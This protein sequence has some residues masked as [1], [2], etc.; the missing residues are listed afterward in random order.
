M[1]EGNLEHRGWSTA[2]G[3]LMQK[4]LQEEGTMNGSREM[5]PLFVMGIKICFSSVCLLTSWYFILILLFLCFSVPECNALSS[6]MFLVHVLFLI[7][8]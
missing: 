7:P 8:R 4:A 1:V 2:P 3:S 5:R 6:L